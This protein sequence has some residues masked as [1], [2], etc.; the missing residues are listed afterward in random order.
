M[1][2]KDEI[3]KILKELYGITTERQLNEAL[4]KQGFINL[5]PFCAPKKEKEDRTA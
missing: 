2:R 3:F 5:A 1:D 4:R